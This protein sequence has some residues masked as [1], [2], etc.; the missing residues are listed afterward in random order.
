MDYTKAPTDS[1]YKFMSISGLIIFVF[2][3]VYPQ[4]L[5]NETSL[6]LFAL[7]GEMASDLAE[8]AEWQRRSAA[9]GKR[10]SKIV[11]EEQINN[12]QKSES[13]RDMMRAEAMQQKT[14]FEIASLEISRRAARHESQLEEL[15]YL[16][17][18]QSSIHDTLQR[19]TYI[20]Y[21]TSAFGFVFWYCKI[22]R[23]QDK[24]LRDQA[25]ASGK[26]VIESNSKNAI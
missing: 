16:T 21:F 14:A 9:L 12:D 5:G 20:A 25:K 7:K 18:Q 19:I 17:K 22:Q 4:Q 6:R 2:S 11:D 10:I 8:S 3:L 23:H 15:E 26:P 1:L 24:I 13:N